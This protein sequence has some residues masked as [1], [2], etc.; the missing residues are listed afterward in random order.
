ML[1]EIWSDVVCPWCYIGKRRF[2]KAV[3]AFEHGDEVTVVWRSFELDR[4]APVERTGT[5]TEMLGRKY[6][7]GPEWAERS[8]QH[9]TDVAAEEGLEF[10]FGGVRPGNTFDAHRLLHLAAER[11]R[12]GDLKERL[13]RAYFTDGVPVGDRDALTALAVEVG[14]DAEEVRR[15]LDEGTY[16]DHVRADQAAAEELDITGVPYFVLDRR[17]AVSGAQDTSVFVRA[18]DKAWAK[19]HPLE[20][21]GGPAAGP[22]DDCADGSCAV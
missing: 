14:L 19:S 18:L 9:M 10:D 15:V 4:H 3:A 11:G 12:Q 21:V 13:L 6:G 7:R 8:V 2:E 5:Y 1:V 20:V 22:G 16:G 17:F